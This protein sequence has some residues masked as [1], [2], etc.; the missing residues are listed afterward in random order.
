MANIFSKMYNFE[1]FHFTRSERTKPRWHQLPV[2]QI[3]LCKVMESLDEFLVNIVSMM[4][5]RFKSL[6]IF[7]I[8]MGKSFERFS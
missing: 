7:L 5:T 6:F 4:Y 1:E 3:K 8:V 2:C